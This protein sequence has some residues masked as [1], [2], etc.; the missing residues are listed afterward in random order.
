MTT[1]LQ[2]LSSLFSSSDPEQ[3]HR[4][5]QIVRDEVSRVGSDQAR[6]FRT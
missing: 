4:A 2:S 1:D 5:L 3:I 6:P